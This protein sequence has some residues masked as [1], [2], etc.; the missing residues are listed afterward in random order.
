MASAY[1]G[2]DFIF[3]PR[4]IAVV[5]V[6]NDLSRLY[7]GIGYTKA[8]LD[9]GFKG[10][11][12]AVG[13]SG[14]E[15][16]GLPIYPSIADV[17]GDVD[18]V[19]CT[20]PAAATPQLVQE[21]GRKG[22][23]AI[24]IFSSGYSEI[25]DPAGKKL[26]AE[27]LEAAQSGSVRI[28]GPNCMGV[29]CPSSGMTFSL[30]HPEQNPFPRKGGPLGFIAQSGVYTAVFVNDAA[31]RYAYCSK[32]VSYGNAIDLNE[33]HF[34]EYLADDENTEI[35]GAYIEGIRNGADFSRALKR[36]AAVKPVIIYKAGMTEPG[37]RAAAS[38]TSSLAGS[39]RI[40]AS[41]LEQSGAIQV[42]GI[43]E[44]VDVSLL[45]LRCQPGR[46]RNVAII[47]VGG[48]ASVQ[49]ADEFSKAGLNVPRLT[50]EIRQRLAD[51]YGN[52]VGRIFTNPI[53]VNVGDPQK[54]PK[55][56][57][58]L[59][60]WDGV[61]SLVLHLGFDGWSLANRKVGVAA[62]LEAMLNME[63][64]ADKPLVVALH[65][66]STSQGGLLASEVKSKLSEAGFAVY[67]SLDIAAAALSRFVRYHQR[68]G[69]SGDPAG[70]W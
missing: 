7:P 40:W 70:K 10:K 2:L 24:H 50:T 33:S 6:S 65:S 31:S 36:A 11:I 68:K 42:Y 63:R 8:L 48:G 54:L 49:A 21:C 13:L 3:H 59:A 43:G 58:V 19:I 17:P 47:G 57:S 27:L 66:H 14:G 37:T 34:L 16:F 9:A 41:L 39:E 61:D 60:G 67:P 51:I 32:A 64:P 38:H 53:D 23:K 15:I 22:V 26:E 52:E 62:F 46:G 30:E 69:A 55:A 56:V 1:S 45:F 5:G 29:Y 35:I 12:Y 28:V 25:A 18:Y 4:S 20:I 44:V